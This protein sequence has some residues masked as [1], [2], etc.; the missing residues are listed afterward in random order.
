LGCGLS[1]IFPPFFRK[2]VFVIFE[3]VAFTSSLV[4]VPIFRAPRPGVFNWPLFPVPLAGFS[5]PPLFPC[6]HPPAVC[7]TDV[8]PP[9][10]R[11]PYEHPFFFH[12]WFYPSK[13]GFRGPWA[14]SFFFVLSTQTP[15]T[16]TGRSFF[17][18]Y[19]SPRRPPLGEFL[20]TI[21][22]ASHHTSV[23]FWPFCRIKRC[24]FFTA[25]S[26][27]SDS[28]PPPPPPVPRAFH[29]Q[30]SR[31]HPIFF[32]AKFQLFQQAPYMRPPCLEL[33]SR[34]RPTVRDISQRPHGP[35]P[36]PSL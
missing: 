22:S 13:P 30:K 28:S 4:G 27:G 23:G 15:P 14:P 29:S 3:I 9:P 7:S 11:L 2:T 5:P 34:G 26:V 10:I 33:F 17:L 16:P 8:F 24:P 21:P 32:P 31:P 36:H 19:F 1:E 20:R 18:G 6:F 12:L 25:L 35:P